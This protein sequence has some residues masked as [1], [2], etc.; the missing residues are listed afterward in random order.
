MEQ[1]FEL[2]MRSLNVDFLFTKILLEETINIP[3]NTLF[4]N[5]ERAEGL[6]KI[7]SKEL[8]YF[9]TKECYFNFNGKLCKQVDGV[10]GLNYTQL[11]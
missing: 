8:L 6:P 7:E 5:T 3:T 2:F 9:A 1:N 10:V 4:Q 11:D